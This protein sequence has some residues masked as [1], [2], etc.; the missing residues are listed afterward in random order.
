MNSKFLLFEEENI[1]GY[2]TK[3][4]A[5]KSK[6]QGTILG[7]I[8]WYGPW[9]KYTFSAMPQTLFDSNCLN[10]I[11]QFLEDNKNVRT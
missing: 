2:K 10:D 7:K 5:V 4:W 8:G 6:M 11:R 3:V 1:V 9:R